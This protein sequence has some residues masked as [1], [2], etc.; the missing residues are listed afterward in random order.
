[1][2][3]KK[4]WKKVLAGTIALA[5]VSGTIPIIENFIPGSIVN[6]LHA[7]T[8]IPE[9]RSSAGGDEVYFVGFSFVSEGSSDNFEL[10]DA[11]Y[12]GGSL[13]DKNESNKACIGFETD[14]FVEFSYDTPIV[15]TK[16]FFRTGGDTGNFPARNPSA[17]VLY[18]ENSSGQ[19]VVI[20]SKNGQSY[21][22]DDNT[23]VEF[24]IS[25]NTAYKNFKLEITDISSGYDDWPVGGMPTF[26]LSEVYMAGH[27][28]D[29]KTDL[30]AASV[31]VDKE[32]ETVTVKIDDVTVPATEYDVKYGETESTATT[33]FPDD[34]GDY[35]AFVTAK[36]TSE[37]YKGST[38]QAFSI[39][40]VECNYTLVIPASLTVKNAGWNDLES[41]ISVKGTLSKGKELLVSAESKN[42][43]ALKSGD[44]TVKYKLAAT[45]QKEKSY[46]DATA[47]TSFSFTRDELKGDGISY[48]AG[49]VVEDYSNK[50]A[51]IYEDIV[52]FTASIAAT[53]EPVESSVPAIAAGVMWEKGKSLDF[54][55]GAYLK[56]TWGGNPVK[57]L[58]GEISLNF[59]DTGNGGHYYCGVQ[60]FGDYNLSDDGH[61]NDANYGLEI[62]GSGTEADPYYGVPVH[63]PI[64]NGAN[65]GTSNSAVTATLADV[66]VS[67]STT[68]INYH[69]YWGDKSFSIINNGGTYTISSSNDFPAIKSA[70]QNGDILTITGGDSDD[71]SDDF[72]IVF[73]K[74]DSTYT[75]SDPEW[76]FEVSAVNSVVVNGS[77]ITDQITRK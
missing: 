12:G 4:S 18:G 28:A 24:Q 71:D 61:L 59:I 54:G 55:N 44:N 48:K 63:T 67:G 5:V 53:S 69:C 33:A 50:P 77:D 45:D 36:N 58:T 57:M 19:W 7:D 75:I 8:T 2:K 46:D 20:D 39:D 74:S 10:A 42:E 64:N 66:F 56:A 30:S 31:T 49:I 26:Q 43:W 76:Y 52:T 17:W 21:T 15:P 35:F 40:P 34:E 11:E 29:S 51:G 32:N 27:I 6:I 65:S 16:Y 62:K 13:F 70:V 23:A 41:D 47:T 72:N 68:V 9:D 60:T 25:N 14:Y 37:N 3:T 73:D 38:K 22:T 1:M